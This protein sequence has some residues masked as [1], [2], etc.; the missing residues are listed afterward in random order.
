MSDTIE[1]PFTC[2]GCGAKKIPDGAPKNAPFIWT[3]TLTK[4]R[5]PYCYECDDKLIRG[6]PLPKPKRTA[7]RSRKQ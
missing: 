5:R 4:T 6:V 3:D 2:R 1:K 7:R